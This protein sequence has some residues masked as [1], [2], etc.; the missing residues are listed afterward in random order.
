[1]L[2]IPSTLESYR[3]LKDRTI[4]LV[5]ETAEP[6]PK[7]MAEIQTDLM[8]AGYV[9]FHSDPFTQE[10]IE[11][12]KEIKADF[13]DKGKTKGQRLRSV[14]FV[15][16]QQNNQGYEVFD[17][18]YNHHMEKVIMHFKNKLDQ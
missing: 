16:W 1:M 17:D 11:S 18:F 4:K 13:D 10:Q 7:Q 8:K 6:T 9:A 12:L 2:I 5:F 15:W 3:S 14:L